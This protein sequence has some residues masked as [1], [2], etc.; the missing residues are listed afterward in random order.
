MSSQLTGQ[1]M[2]SVC[3]TPWETRY[4]Y[5]VRWPLTL[6]RLMAVSGQCSIPK[7]PDEVCSKLVTAWALGPR[8]KG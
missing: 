7:S 1:L 3:A 5:P 6:K 2:M 8:V 4:S